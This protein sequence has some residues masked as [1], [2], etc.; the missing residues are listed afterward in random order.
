MITIWSSVGEV[1]TF[2]QATAAHRLE[3]CVA[4]EAGSPDIRVN[5]MWLGLRPLTVRGA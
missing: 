2:T 4:G 3:T 1:T 5:I